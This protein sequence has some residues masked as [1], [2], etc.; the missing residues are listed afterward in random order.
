MRELEQQLAELES[1]HSDTLRS[2]EALQH[3]YSSVKGELER[4]RSPSSSF[5]TPST[6]SSSRR[7][8]G[9]GYVP[10]AWEESKVEILDPLLFDV[11]AF[12][13]DSEEGK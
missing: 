6:S 13:F 7:G 2:Y 3:E 12:C 4:L 8:G 11:S 1:R 9:E 10:A 5:S